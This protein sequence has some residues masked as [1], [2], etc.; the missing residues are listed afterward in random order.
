MCINKKYI[1]ETYDPPN[2]GAGIVNAFTKVENVIASAASN[3]QSN[4]VEEVD[5]NAARIELEGGKV[6]GEIFDKLQQTNNAWNAKYPDIKLNI[7]VMER[8]LDIIDKN[9]RPL[10]YVSKSNIVNK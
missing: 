7:G 10:Q 1:L 9:T 5:F 2:I 8:Q 6:S 3:A 4:K